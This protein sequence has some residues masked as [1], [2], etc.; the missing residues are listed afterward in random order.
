VRKFAIEQRLIDV[1]LGMAE[2]PSA[3]EDPILAKIPAGSL[4]DRNEAKLTQLGVELSNPQL[5]MEKRELKWEMDE[6]QQTVGTI[7]PTLLLVEMQNGTECGDV[8]SVAWPPKDIV[9]K[10]PSKVSCI[11]SLGATPTRFSLVSADNQAIRSWCNGF[12][13]SSGARDDLVIVGDG[14]G[15]FP[16][17]SNATLDRGAGDR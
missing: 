14:N 15:C 7:A 11:F 9:A 13:F 8:A 6:F 3:E 2:L 12:G 4:L 17:A 10:D 16:R 5:L 1:V